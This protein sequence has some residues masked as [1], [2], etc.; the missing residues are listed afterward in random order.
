MTPFCCS[1]NVPRHQLKIYTFLTAPTHDAADER[2][3]PRREAQTQTTRCARQ[4]LARR[5]AHARWPKARGPD[6]RAGQAQA[7]THSGPRTAHE[8]ANSLRSPRLNSVCPHRYAPLRLGRLGFVFVP[9][10]RP[11]SAAS[12]HL[13]RPP[14]LA[15]RNGS[16]L[17]Q[18]PSIKHN[19]SVFKAVETARKIS[20]AAAVLKPRDGAVHPH[21]EPAKLRSCS[22]HGHLLERR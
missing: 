13:L 9:R 21:N 7:P 11:A 2:H 6:A 19:K 22:Q 8:R 3:A 17:I 4:V 18:S 12:V 20:S 14:P 10:H 5:R 16:A 15:N 1:H